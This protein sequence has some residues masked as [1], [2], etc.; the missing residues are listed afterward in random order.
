MQGDEGNIH[1]VDESYVEATKYLIDSVA[2]FM[3]NSV[4]I[5][6]T[7]I[8]VD[9]LKL[10]VLAN[11][12]GVFGITD[13]IGEIKQWFYDRL[14][15][16]ASLFSSVVDAIVSPIKRVVDDVWSFIQ[17]IPGKVVGGIKTFIDSLSIAVSSIATSLS[18][19]FSQIVSQISNA[20]TSISS[21]LQ[22]VA[23]SLISSITGALSSVGSAIQNTISS[24]ISRVWDAIQ[25]IGTAISSAFERVSSAISSAVSGVI[26]GVQTFF[27]QLGSALQSIGQ[28]I[29]GSIQN[30]VS[31]V[32]SGVQSIA[33]GIASAVQNF[34][35]MIQGAI[36][37]FVSTLTSLG[38]RLWSG[39]QQIGSS[40][41]GVV[42]RIWSGI[43][44]IGQSI[45]G[46][47]QGFA[48]MVQGAIS[49]VANTLSGLISRALEAIQSGLRFVG[50]QLQGLGRWLLD[51][52]QGGLRWLWDT[53]SSI[54]ARIWEGLQW[55]GKSVADLFGRVWEGIQSGLKWLLDAL[56][57]IGTRIWDGIQWIGKSVADMFIRTWDAVKGVGEWVLKGIQGFAE[58]VQRVF[59][60]IGNRVMGA[61]STI[62]GALT[63]FGK[64]VV[65]G[66][67]TLGKTLTD[68]AKIFDKWATALMGGLSSIGNA[69]GQFLQAIANLPQ[70]LQNMFKGV[71]D[72]FT[73]LGEGL[74]EF[75]SNPVK[76]LQDNII[77]PLWSGLQW[78]GGKIW[79]GLQWLW[80]KIVEGAQW[81]WNAIQQAGQ[82]ILNAFA[83]VCQVLHNAFVG[84]ANILS[85]VGKTI[86]GFFIDVVSSI[87]QNVSDAVQNFVKGVISSFM[88]AVGWGTP[89]GLTIDNFVKAW[90]TSFLWSVPLFTFALAVEIP[91]RGIAFIIKYISRALSGL[92]SRLRVKLALLGIG[93]EF[94]ANLIKA[95][96]DAMSN[97]SEELEKHADK[98]YE[99]FWMG[100]GFWYGKFASMLLTYNLR[101]FIPIEMPTLREAEE[102]WNRV[103]ATALASFK[104]PEDVVGKPEDA[105]DVIINF[106]KIRGYSDYILKLAFA[107]ENE[108]Y[109]EVDDRF[110]VK[111]K[112][113]LADA[114]R[115][116]TPSDI[117][118]MMIRDVIIKPDHFTAVMRTQGFNKDT[119]ILYYYLHYKYPSPE[120]LADF[121]WRGMAKVLWY[122]KTLEEEDLKIFL[123]IET[124]KASPPM[125]INESPDILNKMIMM[126]M[127]WYDYAPFP[128]DNEFPT[129]KSI[130]VELMADL[131][132]KID[133]RWL[134]RYGIIEHMSALGVKMDTTID[135]IVS[136]LQGAK[137]NELLSRQVSPEISL[138][139]SLLSRFLIA[140][141]IHPYFASIVA[142]AESHVMLADEMSLLRSGFLELYR[143][144]MANVDQLEQLMSGLFVIKFTT[145]YIDTDGKP[146][147]YTYNKPVLWLPAERRLL[148]LR[149]AMDRYYMLF[150]DFVR[151]VERGVRFLALH[152]KS[153]IEE[154]KKYVSGLKLDKEASEA[155]SSSLSIL[156]RYK[157]ADELIRE[158]GS[159]VTDMLSK[160]VKAISGVDIRFT[161][162]DKYI[163]TWI[164]AAELVRDIE[165]RTWI[166]HYATRLVA[167]I[168]YRTSYGWT[169]VEKFKNL[170]AILMARGWLTIEE[171]E[172]L[173]TVA[174]WVYGIVRREMIP[175]PV[176]LATFS[177]Y[178][179]VPD[180]IIDR[181]LDEHRIPD[182]YRQLYKQYIAFRFI[183]S[184]FRTYLNRA[185]RA[186]VLGIISE[187]EW[188]KITSEAINKYGFRE[189]EI[190]IMNRLAELEERIELVR[191]WKPSLTSI[192][193]ISEVVPIPDDVLKK[194][195]D[196]FK[197][198]PLIEPYVKDYIKRKPLLDE[199]RT[200]VNEYYR[201]KYYAS[202]Y[203]QTI[204]QDIE[205]AVQKYM[206]L[207]GLTEEEKTIRDLVVK[208][209]ETVEIWRE[210]SRERILTPSML[211]TF[212]EYMVLD[213]KVVEDVLNRYNV[214]K[215]YWDLWKKY[216]SVRPIK[217][218]YK[219]VIN[220]ALKALR[221][222]AISKEEWEKILNIAES[223][224]FTPSE[225]SIL[226]MRA[227]LELMVEE[228]KEWRPTLLTLIS[229]IEYVPEAFN[230]LKQYKVDPRFSQIIEKYASVKPLV[231]E[232]RSLINLYYR[233]YNLFKVPHVIVKAVDEYSKRL[234]FT[235]EELR[236]RSLRAWL[237][238]LDDLWREWRLTPARIVSLAEYIPIDINI[239][240]RY[241]RFAPIDDDEKEMWI[242]Y[243][244]IR[245][246]KSDY[247]AVISTALRALR[248]RAITED[249]WKK[250]LEDAKNY[251]FKDPEIALLQLRSDLE[252]AIEDAREYI[253]TPSMLATISEYV[254]SITD[255]MINRVLEYRRVPQEWRGI[256]IQYIKA[257]IIA[258]EVRSL[259]NAYY[260]M[261]RYS[262]Y[263]G[264]AVPKDIED[265]VMKYASMIG[266]TDVEKSIRDLT[267]YIEATTDMIRSGEVYPTL[268]TLVTMAEYINVPVEYVKKVIE[269]RRVEPTYA[270]LWLQY[271]YARSI[272]G[273]V[274]RVV[275]AFEAIYTR[276]SVP[277][278]V[279]NR[280]TSLMAQGGWT[281]QELKIFSFELELRRAYRVLVMLVPSI[282]QFTV[283]A[284]YLPDYEKLFQ[285]LLQVYAIDAEKYKKQVEYYKRLLKNRRLWRHFSWYRTQ[286]TY[287]YMYGAMDENQI[288][289]RLQQ[290]VN[291]G[292]IDPDEVN[293]IVDG[294]K[295]RAAA[296]AAY[297]AMR[298]G[299]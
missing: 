238:W 66:F 286:L 187:D 191:T 138:D 249:R 174:E 200:I 276:F 129:D 7:Q 75:I 140:R 149:S 97:F 295:I 110:K 260:R 115:V 104:I 83:T 204:P 217:A 182:E 243:I 3:S 299:S 232:F 127:K 293:M 261:K 230:L 155:V 262:I 55:F 209:R 247:R 142:V 139:V 264:Y 150:R 88:G 37:G 9:H 77:S 27:S 44:S 203:K 289:Q 236:L 56:T 106:L 23:S 154:V 279:V 80:Q 196:K 277:E 10:D 79:E 199:L 280:V 198:D 6:F 117:I 107:D 216:I 214:P 237:D 94:E 273:E 148:Q 207:F 226:Q 48:S 63:I 173:D 158:Y 38:E 82:W 26:Q 167:W 11:A 250:I 156:E 72:F 168:I 15:E 190:A 13:P 234:G 17:G 84:L 270:S 259:L 96:G 292:L 208:I 178:M 248:Y 103:R 59:S 1:V 50:D 95:I 54:G 195:F 60:D 175:T 229:M 65:D 118:T 225:I 30:L 119:S 267:A 242:K 90:G 108:F 271:L 291:I 201:M 5:S 151:E 283:D 197:I 228:S 70:T 219:S 91:I 21:A 146:H 114:W 294:I 121:Y 36:Q 130:M 100:I 298:Y 269:A 268:S 177:E 210:M 266:V 39:I 297:R 223:Y 101:N 194:I 52:I 257:R 22:N 126:Y 180:E 47:V 227:D 145:G 165:S 133:F 33:Q 240:D 275:S 99:P 93:G 35:S 252:L 192:A 12:L 124:Y 42:E 181:V 258:D 57:G 176:Q 153:T 285:D 206:Q 89:P 278:E 186:Y 141:G 143:W 71:I 111:R 185:R 43:Q 18:T 28:S 73:R 4:A 81:L 67:T 136:T 116:P 184:D 183:K 171:K 85:I 188:N 213:T 244:M 256:W 170:T 122:D 152:T 64:M 62:G 109:I 282:R 123:G 290:F 296:Y 76:W 105:E 46:A 61:L 137:G 281:E 193:T 265:S 160:E 221:Y 113:P 8:S 164:K 128:W 166:R 274:N 78:L 231:D 246:I 245:P 120:K 179:K 144:G 69:F 87:S 41:A 24:L 205:Q 251:G 125:K 45:A 215:E 263:Y 31:M 284:Q 159:I 212:S 49:S 131:P 172:F 51:S 157:K 112:I 34:T 29:L 288:R 32:Q 20:I 74:R 134:T 287:A 162:D 233:V 132:D 16:I 253:P 254:P 98:F 58:Q 68:F 14:K 86:Y 163:E 272:S 255:E 235:E 241:L 189:D 147:T 220:V 102:L 40:I 161:L 53:L 135:K 25:G 224:G 222:G 218:D 211:A 2:Q 202:V 169:P 239:V 92:E 19:Y